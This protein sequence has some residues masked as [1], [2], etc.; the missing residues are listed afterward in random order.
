MKNKII[1][2]LLLTIFCLSIGSACANSSLEN[3]I[4]D[5]GIAEDLNTKFTITEP[6]KTEATLTEPVKTKAT[7]TEPVKTGLNN[8]TRANSEP[9]KTE[10]KVSSKTKKLTD[11]GNIEIN[12]TY[13]RYGYYEPLEDILKASIKYKAYVEKYGKLPKTIKLGDDV[14][15]HESFTYLMGRAIKQINVGNLAPIEPITVKKY[16][17]R[18]DKVK[19][20]L[21]QSRYL[22]LIDVDIDWLAKNGKHPNYIKLGEV[23]NN[24]RYEVYSYAYSKI[25]TWYINHDYDLPNTCLFDSSVFGSKPS[26][27]PTPTPIPTPTENK[28]SVNKILKIAVEYRK[29]VKNNKEIPKFVEIGDD[30]YSTYQFTYL[31]TKAIDQINNKNYND[32]VI[33]T[34]KKCTLKTNKCNRYYQKY[35]YVDFANIVSKYIN[36]H[37]AVPSYITYG[38]TTVVHKAYAYAFANIL[39]YVKKYNILPNKALFTT[40]GLI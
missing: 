15:S 36:E 38:G 29:Y 24:I 20:T 8:K 1:L 37:N 27:S 9:V 21:S 16:N 28:I 40:N 7:T 23:K 10:T 35:N 39:C 22:V 33:P 2:V 31:M 17:P 26:P 30:K 25:L 14:Y 3:S 4:T 18:T 5:T 6:V 32:I 19:V 34:V 13:Q 11:S 12:R